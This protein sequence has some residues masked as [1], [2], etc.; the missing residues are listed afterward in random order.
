[1]VEKPDQ[2]ENL[3]RSWSIP[4]FELSIQTSF[5]NRDG[6]IGTARI[7]VECQLVLNVEGDRTPGDVDD[8]IRY[9]L[10]S[11][12]FNRFVLTRTLAEQNINQP[13]NTVWERKVEADWRDGV[14]PSQF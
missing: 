12:D 6:T 11:A 14:D 13:L 1:M 5:Q 8:F 10:R 3:S 9:Y 7:P 4:R 2:W